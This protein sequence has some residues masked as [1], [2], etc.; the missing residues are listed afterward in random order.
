MSAA[1][2]QALRL[3]ELPGPTRGKR[4][5]LV[6]VVLALMAGLENAQIRELIDRA[7]DDL[8]EALRRELA[9]GER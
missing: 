5:D 8:A 2:R 9:R 3:Q 1:S 4:P 7:P 6:G